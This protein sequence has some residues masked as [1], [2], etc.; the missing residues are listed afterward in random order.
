MKVNHLLYKR[1]ITTTGKRNFVQLRSVN[2]EYPMQYLCMDIKYV[3][4]HG[5]KHN[6]Y[7]L[8]IM[9][10]FSRK[11]LDFML[12]P[13]IRQHDVI[14]LISSLLSKYE[15]PVKA[16]TIRNDNGCQFIAHRVREYLKEKNIY[17]EFSHIAT[18]E[19]NS[20][21]EALNGL[22]QKEVINRYEFDSF[23]HAERTITNYFSFYN[24][25][26]IHSALNYKTP[27][28]VWNEYLNRFANSYLYSFNKSVQ[29]IRG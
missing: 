21:I 28:Q 17:Q 29:L 16:I 26:R 27:N 3:Y 25:H 24:E 10:L 8:T 19:D 2:A 20:Y 4:V 22:L 23:Y 6:I 11:A 15:L 1:T 5:I 13:S 12:K 7:L 9:D 18:P 14:L